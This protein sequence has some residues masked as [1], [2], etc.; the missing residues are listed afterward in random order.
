[1]EVNTRR[2]IQVRV[3]LYNQFNQPIRLDNHIIVQEYNVITFTCVNARLKRAALNA[4]QLSWT[5][6]EV[7]YVLDRFSGQ[8]EPNIKITKK[9]KYPDQSLV[10][11]ALF[12]NG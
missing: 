3:L 11:F 9:K 10:V 8:K 1:M 5:L 4:H 12:K 2:Y 7:Y 6:L